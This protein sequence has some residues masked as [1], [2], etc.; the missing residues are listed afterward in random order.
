MK[1]RS[2]APLL[3]LLLLP[4]HGLAESVDG[5]SPPIHGVEEPDE[6]N[7]A[8][9]ASRVV[10]HTIQKSLAGIVGWAERSETLSAELKSGF[11]DRH[12]RCFFLVSGKVQLKPERVG[13]RTATIFEKLHGYW[14]ATNG[15]IALDLSFPERIEDDKGQ[16]VGVS[17][18]LDLVVIAPQVVDMLTRSAINAGLSGAGFFL[19]RYLI[20]FLQNLDINIVGKA[21]AR[22]VDDAVLLSAGDVGQEVISRLGDGDLA[23]RKRRASRLARLIGAGITA[24]ALLNYFWEVILNTAATLGLRA[25]EGTIGAVLGSFLF[26]GGGA[27]VGAILGAV[28]LPLL[29]DVVISTITI[30]IPIWWRLKKLLKYRRKAAEAGTPDPGLDA[31]IAAV[32]EKL[33]GRVKECIETDS[34]SFFDALAVKLGKMDADERAVLGDF[35]ATI[36]H[37]LQWAVLQNDNWN[38][39]R[40]YYQL[41]RAIG[42]DAQGRP[43]GMPAEEALE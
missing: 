35:V 33:I 6:K 36:K 26:P 28:A 21:L 17:F 18:E 41:L 20:P 29:G 32:E 3:L 25:I 38:A 40:K 43:A 8:N 9:R 30:D 22:T 14:L 23:S 39:A 13:P 5:S 31:S 2:L 27:I 37:T 10:Y 34:Y 42:E 19:G 1:I 15:P 24:G 4:L 11:M 7:L 12:N 16:L